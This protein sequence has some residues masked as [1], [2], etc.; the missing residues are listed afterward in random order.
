[1]L[2]FD[3][4]TAASRSCLPG[5]EERVFAGAPVSQLALAQVDTLPPENLRGIGGALDYWPTPDWLAQRAV[6]WCGDLAGVEVLEPS[7]G[8]GSLV[9]P[10]VAAGAWVSA[11]EIDPMHRDAL[12]ASRPVTTLEGD[13]LAMTPPAR[14]YPLC[15]MNP[16]F[17]NGMDC[18]FLERSMDWANKTV[19][20]LRTHALH[21]RERFERVWS[22]AHVYSVAFLVGRPSFGG[23]SPQHEFCVVKFRR[24][25]SHVP[26]QRIEWWETP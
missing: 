17:A 12:S 14:R 2:A 18:A 8:S 22:K 20:I 23:G 19:A 10:L 4:V 16:P 6:D 21:G 7:A 15:V 9:R 26:P 13:F 24:S 25:S 3:R 11:V 1:M 5:R